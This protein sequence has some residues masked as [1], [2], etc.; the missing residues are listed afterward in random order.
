VHEELRPGGLWRPLRE[1]DEL[2]RLVQR[3]Q[4]RDRLR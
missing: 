1:R 3:G 4:L 2:R